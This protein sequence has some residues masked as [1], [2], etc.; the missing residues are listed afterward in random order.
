LKYIEQNLHFR[1]FEGSLGDPLR[2]LDVTNEVN[3]TNGE[4][5]LVND[6]YSAELLISFK[7]TAGCEAVWWQVLISQHFLILTFFIVYWVSSLCFPMIHHLLTKA[8]YI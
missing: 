3:E 2:Y 5:V 6:T 1:C 4:M 7:L 8:S